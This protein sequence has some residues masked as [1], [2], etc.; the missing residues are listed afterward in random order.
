MK[1]SITNLR[2][3]YVMNKAVAG[4]Y[5]IPAFQRDYVWKWEQISDL[6][7]SISLGYPIGIITI[8]NA[9]NSSLSHG[10]NEIIESITKTNS[11]AYVVVD[12][13][14]RLTSI[15]SVYFAY[16]LMMNVSKLSKDTAKII[17]N[18]ARNI[19]FINSKFLT[20]NEMKSEYEGLSTGDLANLLV[21][22]SVCNFDTSCEVKKFL[23]E[24]ELDFLHLQNW[25]DEEVINIFIAMNK[26]GKKLTHV[27]LMNGFMFNVA[28]GFDLLSFI[29]STSADLDSGKIEH[30]FF[31]QMMKIFSDITLEYK[32]QV[33]FSKS[34]LLDFASRKETALRFV[35]SKDRFIAAL[36]EA[37][38]LLESEFNFYS[39]DHLPKNVYL[40]VA[41]TL[42]CKW[43][44]SYKNK[45]DEVIRKS[46][47]LITARLIAGDYSSSPGTK[48]QEDINKYIL[49]LFSTNE[50][51]EWT[52]AIPK[53]E[54]K[55]E[56]RILEEA[57]Q[58][59]SYKNKESSLFKLMKSV[60][61]G[62]NPKYILEEKNV[63]IS[64]KTLGGEDFDLHH[65]IPTKS[66][67]SSQ[68][69]LEN[70][71]DQFA[72]ITLIQSEENRQII[73]NENPTVY[74]VE[75]RKKLGEENFKNMIQSHMFDYSKIL[76]LLS[77]VEE[78]NTIII[79]EIIDNLFNQR[80]KL[81]AE[82]IL[83][84]FIGE[85]KQG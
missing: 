7:N 17:S 30:E 60:L 44:L 68:F 57:L 41:L 53:L 15:I 33:N 6:M 61:L 19:H 22:T 52:G 2:I 72:N 32:N 83:T 20:T 28:N 62:N 54:H 42:I 18:V 37:L 9:Q 74:L 10:K 49:R 63:P 50:T 21:S 69:Q 80:L 38:K 78:K 16:E 14:Q 70:K 65:F 56:Q 24:Y 47:R 77:N 82:K 67:F 3:E 76:E 29:K 25:T 84:K 31:A 66:K 5:N 35:E 64:R 71:T 75:A 11:R 23:N 8:S 12:G 34:A 40:Q 85:K 1:K 27:D 58:K 4:D 55:Y 59:I 43:N 73:S 39:I 13:Q 79:N 46:F 45:D 26:G 48:A 81:I 51:P 36:R